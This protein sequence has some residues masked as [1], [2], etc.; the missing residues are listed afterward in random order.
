METKLLNDP[1]TSLSPARLPPCQGGRV[2][3][4]AAAD[5]GHTKVVKALLAAG[6]NKEAADK[7]GSVLVARDDWA[8]HTWACMRAYVRARWWLPRTYI[9]RIA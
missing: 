7:V 5:N 2:P 6:A 1:A 3:L 4:H 8:V 9:S